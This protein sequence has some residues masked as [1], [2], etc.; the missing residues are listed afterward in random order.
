MISETNDVL[1]SLGIRTQNDLVSQDGPS[2]ELGQDDFLLLMTTQL[3]NQ[4]PMKPM[5]DGEFLSQMAQFSTASGIGD[6][7]KSFEEFSQSMYSNQAYQA[8]NLVGHS[9]MTTSGEGVLDD[10]GEIKGA[11][12]VPS[13]S[14]DVK[15]GI[16]DQ[17]G[18]LVRTINMGSQQSGQQDFSWDG[19]LE[20]GTAASAGAYYLRAEALY[21]NQTES[22]DILMSS[23]VDSVNLEPSGGLTLN[24]S[25][26]RFV[27]FSDVRKI[28]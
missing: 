7:Q 22:L 18:Q 16:Y 8:A 17:S 27:E 15:V 26:G 6:L 20:D 4:D 21:G 10:S 5:E 28:M 24:L 12:D 13:S 1:S 14:L 23:K 9:V 11:V 2:D 19:L 3:Q 25:D